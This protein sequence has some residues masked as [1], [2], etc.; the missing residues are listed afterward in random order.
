MRI[1]KK[2]ISVWEGYIEIKEIGKARNGEWV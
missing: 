2:K 1:K